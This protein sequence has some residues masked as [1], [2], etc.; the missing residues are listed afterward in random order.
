MAFVPTKRSIRAISTLLTT[1]TR[2]QRELRTVL[3][4]DPGEEHTRCYD[5]FVILLSSLEE[6]L[7]VS[8]RRF[9]AHSAVQKKIKKDRLAARAKAD[10]ERKK[11][12]KELL[13][14]KK[15]QAAKAPLPIENS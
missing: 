1:L 14:V 9:H 2:S 11:A 8:N 13:T 5:K 7:M 3:L 4:D 15:I 10:R 12:A 6:R